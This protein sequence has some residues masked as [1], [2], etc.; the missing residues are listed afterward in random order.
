MVCACFF[1]WHWGWTAAL[2]FLKLHPNMCPPVTHLPT[3]FLSI[4]F[5]VMFCIKCKIKLKWFSAQSLENIC[6]SIKA[7]KS[8]KGYI[9][10]GIILVSKM[11]F[12][13]KEINTFIQHALKSD[14]KDFYINNNNKKFTWASNQH[15]KNY[16][17]TLLWW[18]IILP[19]VCCQAPY[20]N[21]CIN[22]ERL[23]TWHRIEHLVIK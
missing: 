3:V 12:W 4:T 6:K 21:S 22:P 20:L 19:T 14:S 16:I 1:C 7:I 9:F 18:N 5:C 15:F 10:F 23:E 11:F 13:L 17:S 2:F 8:N